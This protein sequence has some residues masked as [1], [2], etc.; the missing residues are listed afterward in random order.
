MINLG[1]T[2]Q[3]PAA[4][5]E[6]GIA[7]IKEI[8]NTGRMQLTAQANRLAGLNPK[9]VL[10]RG[11]SITTNRRTDLLVKRLEDVEIEDLLVTEIA[12]ENLIESKVVKK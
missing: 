6:K 5:M 8:V 9:S 3:T 4:K 10:K 7:A 12:D 2:Y 11:Y 1:I